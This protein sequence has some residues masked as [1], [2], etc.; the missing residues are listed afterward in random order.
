MMADETKKPAS[1][2]ELL[3]WQLAAGV[4]MAMG[5]EP[6]D[7][8]A[9]V[10]TAKAVPQSIPN[11]QTA[12]SPT[13]VPA[14]SS[15]AAPAQLDAS[16]EEATALAAQA[17]SLEALEAMLNE[18]EGCGLKLRATQLV[19]A[20]GNPQADI[21]LIGEAPGRDE[22]IQG[23][24]FV[25]NAGQLLDR[26][27]ASISLDRTQVYMANTVP[28]RPPGNRTPTQSE[29]A[30]CLPFLHRQIALVDPKIVVT[31]GAPA[32]QTLFGN[33]QSISR[34]RGKWSDLEAGGQTRRGLPM[35]HPAYLLR[36]P[37]QKRLAWQDL[38]TLKAAIAAL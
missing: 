15:A 29:I 10:A 5:E 2:F 38:L 33:N 4:D 32:T 11:P 24:P 36:Q 8:F 35:L 1:A 22:D 6:V 31:I 30:A 14:A 21:M 17:E 16:L 7:R 9:A 37:A 18:Y 3:D 12:P 23:K 28:W 13:A 34:V 25:G 27:L 20:D 26:M 19:F